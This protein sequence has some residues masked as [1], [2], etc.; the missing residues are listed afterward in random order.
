MVAHLEEGGV[1]TCHTRVRA[2]SWP[3]VEVHCLVTVDHHRWPASRPPTSRE[4]RI[5]LC[6]R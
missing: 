3:T 4:S 5:R 2:C 1:K 6:I